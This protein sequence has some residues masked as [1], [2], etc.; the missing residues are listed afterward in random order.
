MA[1]KDFFKVEKIRS[2]NVAFPVPTNSWKLTRETE[3]G[4]WKLAEAKPGEQLDSAKT[5]SLSNPLGSPT[6]NDVETAA[7][8]AQLGLDKPTTVTLET[9]DNFNYTLKV[10]AKTNDAYAM[11][12]TVSANLPKER[13][14]GKDE[15]PEDKT[16]LDK[17]FKDKQQKLEE[18]V[19][20]EKP[21]EKWVYLVSN[22]TLEP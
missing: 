20:Q 8:P 17:E 5:S 9:F 11:A 6:F 22:W 2:I 3:S 10:G 21:Y 14:P 4:E 19:A 12:L 1:D 13:T 15:K 16:K 18:K 7:N